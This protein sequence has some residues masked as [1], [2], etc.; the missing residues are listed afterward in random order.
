MGMFKCCHPCVPPKRHPGCHDHCPDY[1]AEKAE[2]DR[3]KEVD[4]KRSKARNDIYS[5]RADLVTKALKR[6][7][8]N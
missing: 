1:A 2:N 3:L 4:A 6:H 7:G 5:Q 8:R